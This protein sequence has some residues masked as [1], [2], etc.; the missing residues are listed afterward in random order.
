MAHSISCFV[1][2]LF[3]SSE[4]NTAAATMEIIFAPSAST[5]TLRGSTSRKLQPSLALLIQLF[6]F[7][8]SINSLLIAPKCSPVPFF[9]SV[10][11]VSQGSNRIKL[12]ICN[13]KESGIRGTEI[14][15]EFI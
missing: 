3:S 7:L 14:S 6:S 9:F 10:S 15:N 4:A 11:R 13:S 12:F 2:L 1:Q 5:L 8:L